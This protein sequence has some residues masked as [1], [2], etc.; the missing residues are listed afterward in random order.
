MLKNTLENLW[1]EIAGLKVIATRCGESCRGMGGTGEGSWD[2]VWGCMGSKVVQ[3]SKVTGVID[4][5]GADQIGDV[6][7]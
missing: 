7:S 5:I 4:E 2:G 1:F 6:A 3:M